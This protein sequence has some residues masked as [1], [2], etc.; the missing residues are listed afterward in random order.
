[1]QATINATPADVVVVATPV[2]LAA[3][4][5]V[6]QPVVRAHYRYDDFGEPRLSALIDARLSDLGVV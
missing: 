4:I 2:D 5:T 6:N 1:L 3:R